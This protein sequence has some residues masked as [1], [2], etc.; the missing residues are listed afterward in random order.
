M[1]TLDI[2]QTLCPK[3][4][5]EILESYVEPLNETMNA[6]SIS[7]DSNRVACFLAQLIHESG[8]FTAVKEN[9]N[10]SA[11][12]LLT[13][14][15][16]YFSTPEIAKE[17]ERQPERIANRVYAN[18]MGND[19][20]TSGD[21]WKYRGRGLI[22][23]TG[24]EN[25]SKFARSIDKNLD[26]TIAFLE[27]PAGACASAGWFWSTNS[28]NLL[29]DKPDFKELTRKINGGYNGLEHRLELYQAAFNLLQD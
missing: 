9:L 25:Y 7:R 29:C 1:V 21:G 15:P 5:K 4:K 19:S 2:L 22:Q 16:K 10:Y 27:S 13:T 12:G 18:R 24:K 28:L 11:Q 3:T 26:E 20:E 23:L 14:F 17:Y 8:D 6:Y